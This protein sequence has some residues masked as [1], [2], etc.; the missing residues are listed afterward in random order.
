MGRSQGRGQRRVPP[1]TSTD[2]T[3][4]IPEGEWTP[5]YLSTLQQADAELGRLYSWKMGTVEKP[6]WSEIRGASPALKSYWQQFDSC[7]MRDGVIYR[8]FVMG[9][10]QQDVFQFLAPR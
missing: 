9:G 6:S 2:V 3:D 8:Q 7:V 5:Q 4:L 1:L 10:G